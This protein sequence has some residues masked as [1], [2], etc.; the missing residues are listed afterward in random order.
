[1]PK[2]FIAIILVILIAFL[3]TQISFHRKI[4]QKGLYYFFLTGT[5]Y[6]IIGYLLGSEWLNILTE[7]TLAK[8]S[9]LI[10]FCLAVVGF[11][12]G[13]QFEFRHLRRIP[14]RFYSATFL[15]DL[16]TFALTVSFF[17]LVFYFLDFDVKSD[18]F[19][20]IILGIAAIGTSPASTLMILHRYKRFQQLSHFLKFVSGFG[21][22][23]MVFFIG[24]LFCFDHRTH[25]SFNLGTGAGWYWL[26]FSVLIGS[27]LGIAFYSSLN[28]R[29][30][31]N[32][33]LALLIGLLAFT[34]GIAA[35]LHLSTIFVS[36]IAGITYANLPRVHGLASASH[37]LIAVERPFYLVL[38]LI[39]GSLWKPKFDWLL[40]FAIFYV[41]IRISGKLL[42]GYIIHLSFPDKEKPQ[43]W[44][45]LGLIAQGGM[46]I[47]VIL[48][49][50]LAYTQTIQSPGGSNL[51]DIN[52]SVSIILISVIINEFISPSLLNFIVNRADLKKRKT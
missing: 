10:T 32:E 16:I 41:L 13:S 14:S 37:A 28:I 30:S 8:L 44:V 19:I 2:Y 24:L 50:Q 21:D 1:M 39:V 15:I 7:D 40:I 36:A 51:L 22:L 27:A 49:F 31:K 6:I 3:G 9:P 4:L 42:G 25:E 18:A 29:Q 33:Y 48:N 47:A 23:I 38:L 17:F 46:V 12:A 5:E 43:K 11:I 35:Y 52:V 20:Y 45:G 34:G 26:F